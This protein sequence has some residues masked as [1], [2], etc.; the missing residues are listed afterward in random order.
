[1]ILNAIE[2]YT[3]EFKTDGV[4]KDQMNI[5]LD[6]VEIISGSVQDDKTEDIV[7]IKK[8]IESRLEYVNRKI[9]TVYMED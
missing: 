7:Q 2:G 6:N 5:C 8:Y 9:D 1:M 3:D 4:A